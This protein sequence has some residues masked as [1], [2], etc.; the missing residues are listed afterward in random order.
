[1]ICYITQGI[2]VGFCFIIQF[3]FIVICQCIGYGNLQISR[4]ALFHIRTYTGKCHTVFSGFC[5][6]HYLIVSR[7]ATVKI[8]LSV[9]FLQFICRT[10]QFEFSISDTV[11]MASDKGTKETS[12]DFIRCYIVKAKDNISKFAVFV[13]YKQRYQIGTIINKLRFHAI[14]VFQCVH[15]NLFTGTCFSKIYLF[16]THSFTSFLISIPNSS[17]CFSST[18]F[19]AS[20]KRQEASFTFGKAIT[21][22]ML[23]SFAISITRRSRP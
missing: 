23:S 18:I 11:S 7:C 9:I 4:I 3:Q 19:G 14:F 10:I 13:R 17:S 2:F 22:R 5:L 21:S 1:M 16:Y 15:G 12:I 20:V 6:I 8:V